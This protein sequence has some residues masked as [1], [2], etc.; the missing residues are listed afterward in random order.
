[1]SQRI[2]NQ[3]AG[4]V[5]VS[6]G[7]VQEQGAEPDDVTHSPAAPTVWIVDDDLGFVWWL[8]GIITEARCRAL[9]ALSCQQALSLMKKVNM[10][11]DV[12]GVN[13]HLPGV[14]GLLRT[15]GR[16]NRNLKIV[17]IQN[18]S[19]RQIAAMKSQARLERPSGSDPISRPEWVEKVRKLLKAVGAAVAV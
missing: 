15:L 13:P 8:G 17:T 6:W 14:A 12:L 1:M 19:E 11:V 9:P 18:A 16:V 3:V 10:G 5:F 2:R 4:V 7:F